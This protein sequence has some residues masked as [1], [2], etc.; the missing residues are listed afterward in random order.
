M[1]PEELPYRNYPKVPPER[2]IYGFLIDFTAVWFTSAIAGTGF[3]RW[4]IFI[5]AWMGLRVF[6]VVNNQGQ[7]LGRWLMD[8]KIIDLRFNK[9]PDLLTL[10]KREGI[11]G[12]GALLATIGL[13]INL[14]NGISMLILV[15]PLITDCAV[16]F[17]DEQLG[18]A[19]HDKIVNSMMI[20][21]ER[22]F[23]LDLRAKK[24]LAQLRRNMRKY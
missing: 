8:T 3:I 12:L 11:I 16:A 4:L 2:R 20:Q 22:G 17:A 15:S 13:D 10:G 5:A 21:T 24:L 18:Q 19:F 6:W 9:I 1:N 23:S 14:S 7:S